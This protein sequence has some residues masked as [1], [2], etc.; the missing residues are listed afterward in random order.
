MGTRHISSRLNTS[1]F[2]TCSLITYRSREERVRA[3]A[4][5][6]TG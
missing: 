3:S 6:A 1:R 4:G 2:S 5:A